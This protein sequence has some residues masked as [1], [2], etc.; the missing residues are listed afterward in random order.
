MLGASGFLGSFLTTYLKEKGH[1]ITIVDRAL[2]RD[3]L[4]KDNKKSS[5]LYYLFTINKVVINC[6]AE[7]DFTKCDQLLSVEANIQIPEQISYLLK[8][9]NIYCIHISTD[10]L[11]E[12]PLNNSCENSKIRIKNNYAMQKYQAEQALYKTNS[13]LLRT[14]FVGKNP[15]KVGMIDYIIEAIQ[16][17]KEIAGWDNIYTS[18]VHI[19]DLANLINLLLH[20]QKVGIFNFGTYEPYTKFNFIHSIVSHLD[21]SLKVSLIKAPLDPRSRNFNCGMNSEKIKYNLGIELPTFSKTVTKC[22]LEINDHITL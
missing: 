13:V 10:A 6:I 9:T 16:Q 14:S 15:R 12:N 18:S 1:D 20:K 5:E 8:Q 19:E 17:R 7:T 22:C 4:E 2:W 21:S 11:Y 3:F